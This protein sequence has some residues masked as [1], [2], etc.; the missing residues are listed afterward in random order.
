MMHSQSVEIRR[1]M[2]SVRFTTRAKS[3][4]HQGWQST[5]DANSSY[6]SNAFGLLASFSGFFAGGDK[7]SSSI[8]WAMVPMSQPTM[9]VTAS[10]LRARAMV[11]EKSFSASMPI[12]R[13]RANAINAIAPAIRFG[14]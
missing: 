11:V 10:A 7:F 14:M 5:G 3:L 13:Q 9:N 4:E 6:R 1:V 8:R 2:P 12:T